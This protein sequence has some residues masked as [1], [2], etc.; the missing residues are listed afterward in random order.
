LWLYAMRHIPELSDLVASSPRKND[1]S[2]GPIRSGISEGRREAFITFATDL[3]FKCSTR[4]GHRMPG[5]ILPD[6]PC[7]LRP[8]PIS[9]DLVDTPIRARC[10]RPFERSFYVDRK[11]L[12]ADHICAAAAERLE[13]TTTIAM[14]K[15][16]IPSLWGPQ[17]SRIL[18]TAHLHRPLSQSLASESTDINHTSHPE[19]ETGTDQVQERENTAGMDVDGTGSTTPPHAAIYP[20]ANRDSP[21]E[22]PRF[23]LVHNEQAALEPTAEVDMTTELANIQPPELASNR[24]RAER[25]TDETSADAL[26]TRDGQLAQAKLALA[27]QPNSWCVVDEQGKCHVGHDNTRLEAILRRNVSPDCTLHVLQESQWR[28]TMPKAALIEAR[29]PGAIFIITKKRTAG[30]SE[31]LAKRGPARRLQ[32]WK[33]IQVDLPTGNGR[34][35][36]VGIEA[37]GHRG[38]K[39]ILQN[40]WQAEIGAIEV[41]S[42]G[43]VEVSSSEK[44]YHLHRYAGSRV[45]IDI[46]RLTFECDGDEWRKLIS[47]HEEEMAEWHVDETFED[48]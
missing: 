6:I 37:T 44:S 40:R 41:H 7:A 22:P 27:L 34:E 18:H 16:L 24:K 31:R 43:T 9:T 20:L 47:S 14:A 29:R 15:D 30:Q 25:T 36:T 46:H 3:G 1:G 10:N 2:P 32:P 19:L 12:F 26:M 45:K 13:Y 38:R 28:V 48:L 8:P 11:H 42:V 5:E 21:T 23:L 35:C 17:V 4:N 33:K 39:L